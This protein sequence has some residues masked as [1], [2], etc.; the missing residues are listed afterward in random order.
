MDSTVNKLTWKLRPV[1]SD[2]YTEPI[3]TMQVYVSTI[4]DTKLTGIGALIA[5]E[6]KV[7]AVGCDARNLHPLKHATMAA[8]DMIAWLKQS[9][10]YPAPAWI[11][12]DISDYDADMDN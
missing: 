5:F 12:A 8:I 6:G 2:C 7:L 11:G 9:K 3:S 10:S 1:L 4:R